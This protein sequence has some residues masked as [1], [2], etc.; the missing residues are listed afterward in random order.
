VHVRYVDRGAVLATLRELA[1]AI[2]QAH[3]EVRA[4][5]L[6]GSLARGERNPYA[7]ADLLI[8]LDASDVLFK[9]RAPLYK[10]TGSPVPL[11]LTVCT[12][13]ELE[14]ELAAGNRFVRRILRES[15]VLFA[16]GGSSDEAGGA[17]TP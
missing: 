9:D 15:Q 14:R 17:R 5:R 11:D 12:L 4:V 8:V 13:A 2:G 10:P 6:F 16:R 1:Q 7:D 3:P